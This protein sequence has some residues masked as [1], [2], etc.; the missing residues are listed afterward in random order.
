MCS[1][2]AAA[3]PSG[4]SCSQGR[5]RAWSASTTPSGSS[6]TRGPRWRGR[7]RVPAR[8][9]KRGV[10]P[11]A[12]RELRH[13]LRGP[14]CQPLRRSAP[15]GPRGRSLASV[16]RAR[17]LQRRHAVRMD[18][19]GTRRRTRGTTG[20]TGR[21]SRYTGGRR[22][23][24]RSSSSFHTASGSGSSAERARGR[25]APRGPGAGGAVTTYRTEEENAWARRWPMEQIWKVR[26]HDS[27]RARA[28]E[29]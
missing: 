13:R 16:G 19:A 18:L 27:L 6:S 17:G 7:G 26:K 28:V 24:A 25:G 20:S 8:P 29:P 3:P 2:S 11:A 1:S 10:R 22:R 4:R 12:G 21:T 23:R 15:L 9:C 14:R 5:A